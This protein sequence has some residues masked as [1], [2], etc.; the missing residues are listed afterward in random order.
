MARTI[1]GDHKRFR[2][3][4]LDVYKGLYVRYSITIFK[5]LD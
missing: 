4:Y 2:E 1:W 3:T 5:G